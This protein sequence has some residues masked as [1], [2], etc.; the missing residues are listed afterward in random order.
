M[1]IQRRALYNSLRMNWVL[2][3]SLQVEAWQ[4]EDYRALSLDT[5]FERLADK[6]LYLDKSSFR[7]FADAVDTPEDLT[8]AL[9]A[10]FASDTKSH[11]QVYLLIFELWRRLLPE[12]PCL[13]VFC[14][15]LDYQVHLYDS[16]HDKNLEA[17]QDALANLQVILDENVDQGA[18]PEEAL[19]GIEAGCANDIEMFLH[20]FIAEQIDGE[21]FSYASEL[22]DGFSNYLGGIKWFE[23]LR[24]RTLAETDPAE[25]DQA[26]KEFLSDSHYEPDL[27]LNLEV[28][29]FLIRNGDKETFE[30]LAVQTTDLLQIEDDFQT[31]LSIC[32]DFYHR[33]DQDQKE[34]GLQTI[35]DRRQNLHP[36]KAFPRHEKDLKEFLQILVAK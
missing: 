20:D 9:W 5:L 8:E 2:D 29:S 16:G 13:S 14:D 27:D 12:K 17:I 24:I 30:R 28:L 3:P 22:V 31:L 35:L 1:E 33:L 15:E 7:A 19:E 25:A 23:F 21:N 11:D 4:V 36:D 26:I 18:D 6:G 34:S 32:A 10:E